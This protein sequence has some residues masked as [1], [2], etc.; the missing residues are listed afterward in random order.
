MR[1]LEAFAAFC[2]LAPSEP[3]D[4]GEQDEFDRNHVIVARQGREPG[5]QLRYGQR[6][7]DMKTWAAEILDAM[8]GVC[9]ML[10]H[11]DPS[12]QYSSSLAVQAQKLADVAKTPSARLLKEM[13]DTGESFFDLALRMSKTYKQYFTELD[14]PDEPRLAEFKAEAEASLE[15]HERLEAA[16]QKPFREYLADYFAP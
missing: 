11:G 15:A 3:I 12:K 6:D 16:P 5:L 10:D 7:A 14:A 1:F 9:E 13:Q 4:F 2:V 8:Q